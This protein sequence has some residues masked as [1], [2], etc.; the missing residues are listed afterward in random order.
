MNENYIMDD[1]MLVKY[2][3]NEATEKETAQVQQWVAENDANKKHYEQLKQIWDASE[4]LIVNA[5]V[6]EEAA[7]SR[8]QQRIRTEEGKKQKVFLWKKTAVGIAAGLLLFITAGVFYN[9]WNHQ[10]LTLASNDSVLTD[11]LSDGTVVTLNKHATLSFPRTFSGNERAVTLNGEAF[12]DVAPNKQKPFIIKA[13]E[14]KIKVVGTSFNVN[15]SAEQTEVIVTTG[16]V[17]VSKNEHRVVLHPNEKA[18]VSNGGNSI[19]KQLNEDQLYN[20]YYSKEFICNGTPLYKL[21]DVLSQ[22]YG[23]EI[24]IANRNLSGLPLTATFRNESLQDVLAVISETFN[25]SVTQENGK[26]ILR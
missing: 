26:I 13:N 1:D 20:Y 21:V 8:L 6:D 14:S 9:S 16:I 19:I 10:V 18:L 24:V 17:E 5:D 15:S 12:F 25:I 7:W 23:K 22:A 11:T 2:L 4:N 3:L